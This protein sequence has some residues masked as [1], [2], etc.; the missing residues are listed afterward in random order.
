[1]NKN[2]ASHFLHL[3]LPTLKFVACLDPVDEQALREPED[4]MRPVAY[5]EF[6]KGGGSF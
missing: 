5:L 6:I 1:M 4:E 2:G 3:P